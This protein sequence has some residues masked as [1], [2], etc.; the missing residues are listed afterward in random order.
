MSYSTPGKD[1]CLASHHSSGRLS[2]ERRKDFAL[3]KQEKTIL[4]SMFFWRG[5]VGQR[6][7]CWLE[8]GVWC[9]AVQPST[10]F[11]LWVTD[12]WKYGKHCFYNKLWEFTFFLSYSLRTMYTCI[13]SKEGLWYLQTYKARK[14]LLNPTQTIWR[15]Y[16]LTLACQNRAHHKSAV[17]TS[18][19]LTDEIFNPRHNPSLPG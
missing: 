6:T 3:F 12:V 2:A 16:L 10:P 15:S 8:K 9:W 18:Q 14:Y 7:M 5:V 19:S 1:K 4:I 11:K 17:H 13:L